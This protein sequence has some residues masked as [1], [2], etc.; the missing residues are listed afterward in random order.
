MKSKRKKLAMLLLSCALSV[1][2]I[3]IAAGCEKSDTP[4]SG[5]PVTV[6]LSESEVSLDKYDTYQLAADVT[7]GGSVTWES[8]DTG[9]VTVDSNGLL[10]AVEAGTA[11]IT[12]SAG[13]A[14]DTCAVTV[15]LSD[16]APVL[17]VDETE[18]SVEKDGQYTL[19]ASVYWKGNPVTGASYTW[20]ASS[21][22]DVASVAEAGEGSFTV[23]GLKD[24][25]NQPQDAASSTPSPTPSTSPA[26]TPKPSVAPT[27]KPTGMPEVNVTK[28]I[29]QTGV[30]NGM[31]WHGFGALLLLNAAGY[32]GMRIHRSRKQRNGSAGSFI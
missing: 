30:E 12:A 1:C 9:I 25:V 2:M 19:S 16:V 15:V 27:A 29:P 32:I 22:A 11:T 6:T 18:I 3:G 8:S 14:S 17:V 5:D 20:T 10:T 21:G 28:P 13:E 24:I 26:A 7:G 31:F 4:P 23:S